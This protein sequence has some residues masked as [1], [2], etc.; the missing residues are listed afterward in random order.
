MQLDKIAGAIS[1]D[2]LSGLVEKTLNDPC[3]PF[4]PDALAILARFKKED[5][6]GFEGLRSQLKGAGCRVTA[7][8][9]AIAEESGELSE[10]AMKQADILVGLAQEAELFH[11][12]DGTSYA[13]LDINGHRETWPVK[14]K[15]FRRW[16]ARRYYEV[17]QGA[18]SSV[19]LQSALSVVEAKA[20]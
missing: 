1:A 15:G 12:P 17:E 5:R 19:A 3:A 2:L 16:I 10:R 8:D 7:L 20:H 4:T 6:A 9:D 18:P 11:A 13:D 14:S